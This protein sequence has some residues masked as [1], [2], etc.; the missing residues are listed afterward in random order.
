MVPV[1]DG[2]RHLGTV[3]FGLSL[4]QGLVESFKKRHPNT[5]VSLFITDKDGGLKVIAS[6]RRTGASSGE[7]MVTNA[8]EVT[9]ALSGRTSPRHL[10]TLEGRQVAAV[11]GSLPDYSGKGTVAVELTL[12][13]GEF[14]AM[15]GNAERLTVLAALAALAVGMLLLLLTHRTVTRPLLGITGLMKRLAAGETSIDIDYARRQD[16]I[17]ALGRA[18]EVF[19]Q[20][21]L[22][23]GLLNERRRG[24]EENKRRR[25]AA[26]NQ[27]IQDFSGGVVGVLGMLSHAASAMQATAHRMA[28]V[29]DRASGRADTV[30]ASTGATVDGIATVASEVTRLSM[31]VDSIS[32]QVTEAAVMVRDAVGDADRTTIIVRGLADKVE[33]IDDIL[34][35]IQSIASQTNLLAL[36]ATIE[37]ARAGEAG[38][39]FAVVAGEVKALSGQTSRAAADI[40][41]QIDAIQDATREVVGAIAGF[42]ATASR[43]NQATSVISAAIGEQ[44]AAFS[45]I[46]NS[47]CQ[48]SSAAEMAAQAIGD[49]GQAIREN[50]EAAAAVLSTSGELTRTSDD[51][52]REVEEFLK[53]VRDAGERR[54]YERVTVDAEVR[55]TLADGR[56]YQVRMGDISLGGA[57]LDGRL[58]GTVGTALEVLLPRSGEALSARIARLVGDVTSIQFRL[59]E[60]TAA[61]ISGF[62]DGLGNK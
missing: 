32:T 7:A 61:R 11:V 12:G 62:M 9:A 42:G 26:A 43:I 47:A 34:G 10:L 5:D 55:V 28:E 1:H 15:L 33:R 29:S 2:D 46:S 13:V 17:G 30:T 59:D 52:R 53:A 37:A 21:A 4:G 8:A 24:E 60:A 51:L 49:I 20:N 35:L 44:D 50:R 40:A 39:G 6:T 18:L 58:A 57:S 3:E 31:T 56:S 16:E 23:V 41:I 36:N 48:A 45:G 54:Q 38:K 22:S 25:Q 19:R 27:L 14:H